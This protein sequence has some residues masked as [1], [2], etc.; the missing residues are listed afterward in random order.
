MTRNP[1]VQKYRESYAS[2]A[3]AYDRFEAPLCISGAVTSRWGPGDNFTRQR[4]TN[5]SLSLVTMGEARFRQEERE[6]R[7][8]AG[9]VFLAH[10]GTSQRFETALDGFL[11]KRSLILEGPHIDTFVTALGLQ[12][13]DVVTP[14]DRGRMTALF[15]RARFLLY[16]KP[17]AYAAMAYATAYE[18][19][20]ECSRGLA[21]GYPAQLSEAVRYIRRNLHRRL[22][23][24]EIAE[25]T[26]LSIRQCNRLF[27]EHADTSPVHFAI[28]QKMAM[29]AGMLN[30]TTATAKQVAAAVGYDDPF[31]FSLQFKQHFGMSPTHY[32]NRH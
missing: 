10:H 11:H 21:P 17:P 28:R 25:C 31:R 27:H 8:R 9:Q 7:V 29:A 1:R 30:N 5:M 16:H 15:R 4:R 2:H 23:L 20:L 18:V 12:G 22:T 13:V 14:S 6:G 3:H 24:R 26:N 19:L 32:R